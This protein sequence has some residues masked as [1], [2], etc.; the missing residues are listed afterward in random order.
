M[1]QILSYSLIKN[2]SFFIIF[3]IAIPLF[4]KPISPIQTDEKE[5]LTINGKR[6]AYYQLHNNQLEYHINGPRRI[7]I[8]SRRA[9][10]KKVEGEK[11]FSYDIQI[12]N[13]TKFT[14]KDRQSISKGVTSSQHPGHGYS[15]S[16]KYLVCKYPV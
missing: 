1:N 3:L 13:N 8:Y 15:K 4:A 14:V 6:R 5:I 11:N 7:K 16:G 10:P 9:V 2:I 12:D